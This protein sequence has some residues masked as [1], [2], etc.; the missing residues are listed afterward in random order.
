MHL[1]IVYRS[2]LITIS[3]P[4]ADKDPPLPSSPISHTITRGKVFQLSIKANRRLGLVS[5]HTCPS[6]Q[7]E[8][9]LRHN[10][11]SCTGEEKKVKGCGRRWP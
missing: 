11:S 6:A 1:V 2:S 8:Q 9:G 7:A 4:T 10:M 5:R 3:G